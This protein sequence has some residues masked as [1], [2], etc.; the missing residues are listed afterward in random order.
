MDSHSHSPHP[1]HPDPVISTAPK[2]V[3]QWQMVEGTQ[4]SGSPTHVALLHTNKIFAYGGSSLDKDKLTKPPS[5]EL[6]DLERMEITAIDTDEIKGD[7]WCGGHT[8]LPDGR[9]L[10]VGGTSYYPKRLGLYGGLNQAYMFDPV[11]ETWARLGDMQMGR[12]YPTL[13]RLPDNSIL[14]IG[15]LR[16][17][18]P[19]FWV[20]L[21]ELYQDDQGWQA[22]A[23]KKLFPLYPR[24]HLLPDG[25]VFYSGVFNTHFFIPWAFPSALWQYQTKHWQ[26]WG[27]KHT[28]KQREEGISLLLALRPP[29]YKAEVLIAGGGQHNKFRIVLDLL[30]QYGAAKLVARLPHN[31]ALA[32]VER[33]DLSQENPTW[34]RDSTMRSPRI[35]AVGVLLPD[36]QVLAVGGMS[37]HSHYT[38]REDFENKDMADQMGVLHAELYNPET[39]TWSWMAP[40]MR[41]RLYHST[42][43]LLP[44]GRVISMGSNPYSGVIEKSIEIYSPPYLCRGDRPVIIECPSQITYNQAFTL[45][46]NQSRQ[47]SQIVLMRLEVLTHVTNT[48]QRLLALGFKV[49]GDDSLE[50]QGPLKTA[51]MPQGYCLLFVLNN[52]GVPSIGKFIKIV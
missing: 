47:I 26:P 24:L 17:K 15:G 50:V 49:L 46:V 27:G 36:G 19:E 37:H 30:N 52:D 10:M 3:G 40:Q 44:D 7:L 38:T 22:M 33:I 32:S 14:T 2:D 39:R 48:D 21:Q 11:S 6:L 8:L 43:L 13:L 25:D 42:A 41:P 51:H 16:D 18:F 9:L 5:A 35:H 28:D 34:Q 23:H 29:D 4:F 12:W 1:N 45:H 20:R 31:Q